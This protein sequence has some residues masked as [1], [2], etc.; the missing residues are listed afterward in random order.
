MAVKSAAPQSLRSVVRRTPS[1]TLIVLFGLL[2]VVAAW[3]SILNR[4]SHER[5]EEMLR[6][7]EGN[8][9]LARAFEEHVRRVLKTADNALLFLQTEYEKHGRVTE[10]MVAFV[11]R[12]KQDPILNQIGLANAAG[13]LLLS[14][15]PLKK[16]VNIAHREHFKAHAGGDTGA[17]FI[18]KPVVNLASG[19]RSFFLSRRLSAADGSFAG[20][21]TAGL[22]PAYFSDYYDRPELGADLSIMLVGLDGVVRAR[23]F[24]SASAAG[25]DI[26][27]GRLFQKELP[28]LPAGH[29]ETVAIIDGQERFSSYRT[30]PDYPLLVVVGRLK[31]TALAHFGERRAGYYLTGLLFTCF[32]AGFCLLL[33]REA[34]RTRDQN[35][36]LTLELAERRKAEEA[37][38]ESQGLF[39]AFM[40]RL[41][42]VVFVKDV[43]GRYLYTN[44]AFRQLFGQPMVG[45]S[46]AE[47]PMPDRGLTERLALADEGAL[48]EGSITVEEVVTDV[49]GR[50]RTFETSKFVVERC[51]KEPVLGGIGFDITE[52]KRAAEERLV[53]ERRLLQSQ[54]LESLG[55]LAGGIAHDFNNLLLSI[56]GNTDLAL[57]KLA[58][59]SPVRGYLLSI[60]QA[61]QRAAD[62]TNQMLAY[63]GRGRF[64][65][66]PINLSRLVEEMG[67]LLKTVVS[68]RATL[69]YRLAGD[70]PAVEADATQLRQVVMNLIIN[71]SDALEVRGGIITVATGVVEADA[72]YLQAVSVDQPLQEGRYVSFEVSD[73]GRGMDRETRARIFDPFFSTK[74][75]GRGLGLAAVLGI[76][77]GH[78]GGIKVCSAPGQGSSF[79]VLL[80]ASCDREAGPAVAAAGDDAAGAGV[81]RGRGTIL[82]VD[83]E[84]S[85][86]ATAASML[87]ECGFSVLTA[88]DG[89]EAL[90]IFRVRSGGLAGVLLDMTMPRMG[91]EEAF[92]EMQLLDPLVPVILSSGY[93]EQDAVSR[94]VGRGLAGFIQKPYRVRTLA[95]KLAQA[96]AA[97]RRETRPAAE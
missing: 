44:Q 55:V 14:A 15:V 87:Q 2:L 36:R 33:A 46:T 56:L 80:P 79:K 25:Q 21:V 64:V 6:I 8:D 40:E 73:T 23:R 48:R 94:F 20:V 51:G 5:A 3:A 93:S 59:E 1:T 4:A 50:E 30:M 24:Q 54:K 47:L 68:K 62:L 88:A 52:R 11:G 83:D 96:L 43:Q 65:V 89:L 32:V 49:Q 28:R 97:R 27:E 29:F 42:A 82:L 84:E 72:A 90:E 92:T 67:Q 74:H 17:L 37:L 19:A 76:V 78:H 95:E 41:P 34:G 9:G 63:S 69:S 70:L 12:A 58:P 85:V 60:E 57:A 38:R 39:S 66:G 45:R 26:S 10:S 16:A 31:T 81:S 86:R 77:R 61:S 53:F 13:D 7:Y 18:G 71:A 91:G 35:S 22:D 75:T